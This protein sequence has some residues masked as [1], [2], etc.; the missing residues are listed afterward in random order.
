MKQR[1][2]PVAGART[3]NEHRPM[4]CSGARSAGGE[5]PWSQL[6]FIKSQRSRDPQRTLTGVP[7]ADCPRRS[8]KVAVGPS[9][10]A[11]RA[12][13]ERPT[14]WSSSTRALVELYQSGRRGRMSAASAWDADRVWDKTTGI[15]RFGPTAVCPKCPGSVPRAYHGRRSLLHGSVRAHSTVQK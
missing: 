15:P 4:E 12:L 7:P 8:Q 13:P 6:C 11:G 2:C 9:G 5:H 3:N 10:S 1:A 14:R